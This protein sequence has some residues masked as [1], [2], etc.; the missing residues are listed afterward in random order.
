MM[1]AL[2]RAGHRYGDIQAGGDARL[3]LGDVN[4]NNTYQYGDEA[5]SDVARQKGR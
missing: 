5:L 3:V 1:S 4:V 2:H